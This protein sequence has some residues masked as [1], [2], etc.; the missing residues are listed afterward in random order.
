VIGVRRGVGGLTV[1]LLIVTATPVPAQLYAPEALDRYFRV[2]W[3]TT[4]DRKGRAV[5][6]Y[7]YNT[8]MQTAY[9]VRLGIARLDGAGNVV[10]SSAI[11]VPGDVPRDDRAYFSASVP[12]AA[13]YRVQVLSFDWA[14]E[15]GGGM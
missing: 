11:W 8:S 9:R 10:G 2:E 14:C 15:G 12:D 1:A 4:R 13:G 5:E 7:L 6:G 3:Q